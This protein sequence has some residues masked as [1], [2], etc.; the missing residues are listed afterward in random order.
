MMPSAVVTSQPAS[1]TPMDLRDNSYYDEKHS[2]PYTQDSHRAL[3]CKLKCCIKR[4]PGFSRRS[5]HSA[6]H[7]S[8]LWRVLIPAV[9]SLLTIATIIFLS[10]LA[11]LDAVGIL[12]PDDGML[13]LDKRALDAQDARRKPTHNR[14]SAF[15]KKNCVHCLT[16]PSCS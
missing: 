12:G 3:S 6:C 14:N 5:H 2:S 15:T 1:L 4:V 9:L 11:D 10:Y 8:R 16:L 13:G 7:R